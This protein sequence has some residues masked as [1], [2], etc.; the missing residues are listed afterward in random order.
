MKNMLWIDDIVESIPTLP[1]FI[2]F[3]VHM[4]GLVHWDKVVI[5]RNAFSAFPIA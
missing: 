4:T 3:R 5:K 2:N 1:F